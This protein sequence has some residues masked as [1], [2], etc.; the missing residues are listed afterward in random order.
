MIFLPNIIVQYLLHSVSDDVVSKVWHD[1][2]S[3][4]PA[5][6]GD[7]RSDLRWTCVTF[8]VVASDSFTKTLLKRTKLVQ[9]VTPSTKIL[10][11]VGVKWARCILWFS[12]QDETSTT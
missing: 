7:M 10:V 3:A 2:L 1:I 11:L 5:V 6:V 4:H 9:G 12:K 8:S